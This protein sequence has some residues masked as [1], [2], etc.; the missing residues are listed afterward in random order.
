MV[1]NTQ[2]RQDAEIVKLFP[3]VLWHLWKARNALVFEKTRY[4]SATIIARAR[5]DAEIWFSVNF[6]SSSHAM[7][8][9]ELTNSTSWKRPEQGTVK[10]N[11][12]SSWTESS[13]SC[14][15]AWILRD[16]N[17]SMLLHSHRKYSSIMSSR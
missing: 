11:I 5:E 13:K 9:R 2:K 12:G 14:G 8:T 17:G 7:S 16:S 15:A 4:D 1:A 3:W 6:S 10:C